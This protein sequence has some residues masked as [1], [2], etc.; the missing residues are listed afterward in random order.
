MTDKWTATQ[1]PDQRGRVVVITG[2]NTGLGFRTA[3]E[4]AGKGADVVLAV[5]NVG[6][7]EQ[8]ARQIRNAGHSANVR[9]VGLDLASLVSIRS[10]ARELSDSLPR[11]DVLINNAGVMWPPKTRT[12]D[13]FEL[14]FGTNHLGHFALTG[15]LL[16]KLLATEQS[17]IVTI[18]SVAHRR[19]K[20]I[21]FNDL[22]CEH[23]YDETLAYSRS[24]LANLL[25]TYELQ[26][27]LVAAKTSTIAVAAHPGVSRSELFRTFP[28][29]KHV[30][31]AIVGQPVERGAWPALRAATDSRVRGGQ[32]WGPNHFGEWRGHPTLVESSSQ[33]HDVKLQTQIWKMSEAL[34]SVQ[35]PV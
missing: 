10:S 33:S 8:A 32:Y 14:Q 29:W 20:G 4:L 3:T 16:N 25:F 5:R 27:R 15:L 12:R 28:F 31:M 21:D 7:G 35:F 1:I 13:G 30:T 26:R 18:S 9:V 22:H 11:I 34:T 23:S 19:R 2:A 6:K 17:R 24:K